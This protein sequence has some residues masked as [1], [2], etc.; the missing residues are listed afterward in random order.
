MSRA[1]RPAGT[2][3]SSVGADRFDASA[4]VGGW[5]GVVESAVPTLV[6]V[7]IM[8]V[9]PTALVPAVVASLAVSAVALVARLAQRQGLTQVLGG[10]VLALLSAAWA[11][12]S[13]RASNF[14]ATGLVINA[15]WLVACLGSVAARWPLVGVLMELWEASTG[16]TGQSDG[17]DDASSAPTG[18]PSWTAWRTDPAQARRRRRYVLGTLVLA[19]MFALRLVVE[20]P[21]YLGGDATVSALGVARLALGLPLFALTCWFVWLL[22]RRGSAD[23]V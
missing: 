19:A 10:A 11:W 3:L 16:E 14:Y 22:V 12:R 9:R 20:L 7:V 4:A 18:P 21:L 13:G 2:G 5:R 1:E 23:A 6:F 15:V 8:A 17:G